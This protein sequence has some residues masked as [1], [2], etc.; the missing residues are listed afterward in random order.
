[1]YSLYSTKQIAIV[2]WCLTFLLLTAC[3]NL[4]DANDTGEEDEVFK[5]GLITN[6]AN[7]LLNIEGFRD[8]LSTLG[9]DENEDIEYLFAGE[10]VANDNLDT[11]IQEF[12]DAGVDLIFTAGTPTGQAAH[13]V[14]TNHGIPV[15]FG[16]IADPIAAGVLE[17]LRTPGGNMT[18][19]R[20]SDNQD[21]R[22]EWLL[23]VIPDIEN[24]LVIY[25]PEDDAPVSALAQV[26]DAAP[27]LGVELVISEAHTGQD[28]IDVLNNMPDDIDAIFLLPDTVVNAQIAEIVEISY[29]RD[30]AVSGPSAIQVERGALMSYGF[31]HYEAGKQAA[32]IAD[33][34]L[35]GADPGDLPV[36]VAEFFLVFNLAAAE[37]ID[38]E[39]PDD[40]LQQAKIII[41]APQEE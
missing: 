22:L 26:Q 12:V 28:V 31:V 18:G 3:G 25:N 19:V 20:L 38:V 10:P 11:A 9:Y 40:I 15:V 23:E 8:G 32:R 13:R 39:I 27:R 2:S 21:R 30:L 5:V 35:R 16:V 17:D 37:A 4:N 14:T 6:N 29:E 33:Q 34:V 24:I 36:E 41:R 1:M 7:G